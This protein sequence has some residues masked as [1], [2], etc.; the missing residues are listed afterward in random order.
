MLTKSFL[1]EHFV[2]PQEIASL[3]YRSKEESPRLSAL[4]RYIQC[5]VSIVLA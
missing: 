3:N 5:R 4:A 1:H 2:A